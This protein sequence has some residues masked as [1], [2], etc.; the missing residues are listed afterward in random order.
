MVEMEE[1]KDK[2]KL[3]DSARGTLGRRGCYSPARAAARASDACKGL[4]RKPRE[5]SLEMEPP[6]R[7]SLQ[8]L[9]D[10]VGA[11]SVPPDSKTW[12]A[13]ADLLKAENL[14]AMIAARWRATPRDV[15][16]MVF[17]LRRSRQ[18]Q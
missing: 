9:C 16:F 7:P 5:R 14:G 6:Q 12:Q 8:P 10:H 13:D 15:E 3:G 1:C 2:W 18:G 11:N 17:A 4:A